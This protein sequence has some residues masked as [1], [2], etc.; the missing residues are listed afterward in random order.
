MFWLSFSYSESEF[1]LL[2]QFKD[3]QSIMDIGYKLPFILF[4]VAKDFDTIHLHAFL[5]KKQLY[6][7]EEKKSLCLI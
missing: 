4:L 3:L 2:Q 5:L 1:V 7:E 6:E